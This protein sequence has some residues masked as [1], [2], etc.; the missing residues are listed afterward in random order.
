MNL[1]IS[2]LKEICEAPGA[3]GFEHGIREIIIREIKPYVDDLTI[4]NIGN[5][6]TKKKG[7]SSNPKKLMFA[8]H[9]DEIGF[10]VNN[11]DKNGFLRFFP[12]GGFDPKA[13]TSQRVIVHG[14]K[15]I[16]GVIGCKPVHVMN[17]EEKKKPLRIED[18]FIDLGMDKEEVEKYIEVG[19]NATREIDL[20]ELGNCVTCKSL[21]NRISVFCLIESVKLISKTPYNLFATFTVQEEVGLR[22]A[23]VAA[24]NIKPDFGI[25]IDTGIA[26]DT[27]DTKG[28]D[29][30]T[31]LGGGTAIKIMDRSVICDYRM[32]EFMKFVATKNN[33]S[34]QPD[35][36]AAGGTDTSALQLGA[37]CI[38]GAISIPT[39]YLH[40]TTETI[41]KKDI[42]ESISLIKAIVEN[43]NNYNWDHK[44]KN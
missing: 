3:S 9:M 17:E 35:I 15:D 36:K 24:Q 34:W 33:I 41:H 26:N 21:D 37:G 31:R 13:L 38:A 6:V 22:G 23:Q 1:N 28:Y 40:Q 4:D 8:A 39:R 7:T 14:K 16:L 27:P 5:I 12:L 19:N 29:K 20:R 18:Y 25:A 42:K 2:L 43:I 44:I 32:V 30:I 11:I 10:I